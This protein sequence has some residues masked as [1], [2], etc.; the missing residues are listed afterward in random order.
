MVLPRAS[1][2]RVVAALRAA[3]PYE[4]PA[5]DVFELA[6]WDD[7][8]GHGRLGRLPSPLTLRDFADEVLKALPETAVGARISGDLDERVQ[9]VALAGGAGDFLLDAVK[10]SE[11]DVYVT[12][13]LRHHPASEFREHGGPALI[14][15]PHWAA[16]WS[17]L[18]V[19]Q[20]AIADALARKGHETSST[21]SR[22]CTDPWNQRASRQRGV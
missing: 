16:E 22:I 17:W 20:R 18:P 2:R 13:D 4:E 12:S 8:R 14:D 3:H 10:A 7:N 11:A 9:T 15:V 1:R 21:V 19:A 6:G 5:F